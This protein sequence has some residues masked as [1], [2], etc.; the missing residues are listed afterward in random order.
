MTGPDLS[1]MDMGVRAQDD[2]YRHI[3]GGWL[4]DFRLPADKPA[5]GTFDELIDRTEERLRGMLEGMSGAAAGSDEGQLYAVYAGCLDTAARERAGIAPLSDLLADIDNAGGKADLARVMGRLTALGVPGL[6]GVRVAADRK[7][8][9]RHRVYLSQSG[10]GMPDGSYYRDGRYAEQ[11][12]AYRTYL[13]RI[14]R[15]ANSA[16]P[17][18]VAARVYELESRIAGGHVELAEF[19]ENMA[20]YN[21]CRWDELRS[22]AP[23]F[24]WT[25]WLAGVTERPQRFETVVVDQPG[26]LPVAGRLWAETDVAV[27]REYLRLKVISRYAPALS[28]AFTEAHF[29]WNDRTLQGTQQPPEQWR[30]AVRMV[31]ERLG[32]A[33]GR[34][35]AARY[36]PAES[37]KL[38]EDLVADLLHAYRTALG[39]AQWM[40]PASRQTAVAKVDKVIA[41]VGAPSRGRDYTGLTIP[42][43][44]FTTVLRAADAFEFSW[45]LGKLERPVDRGEWDFMTPADVNASYSWEINHIC[46]PAAILQ[47]PFFDPEAD[48]AVNYGGIGAVIAHEMGHGFD[49]GGSKYDAD[50]VLRDWWTPEDTAAFAAK[51]SLVVDQ[52]DPLVPEGLKP[53]QHVDGALTVTENLADLRGLTTAL[54]AFRLG[55]QRRGVTDPDYRPLFQAY[56]RMWRQCASPEY[57]AMMVGL[58]S[59]SPAEF[60]VNQVVRN[61]PEFYTAYRVQPSDRMY[62]EPGKRVAM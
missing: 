1:G 40:S 45:Q 32:D 50:G 60:R 24:D 49:T 27:W 61:M 15:A 17:S 31:R 19:I 39:E 36:F 23:G 8:P 30:T 46:L 26:Y 54:A 56:A 33:L 47:P 28:T 25:E 52:Y 42:Q 38:A 22:L 11:Q 57:L 16:D 10:V 18:A 51:T 13:E 59:H 35:Y 44:D 6:I 53:E 21:A 2:L 58:D 12:A 5:Y 7:D 55:E 3:N 34:A 48:A 62:L 37:K 20:S 29:E 41:I 9:T 43:G 14:G 4:R